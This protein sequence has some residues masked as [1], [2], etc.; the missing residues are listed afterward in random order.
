MLGGGRARDSTMGRG[1]NG[2]ERSLRRGEETVIAQKRER[3]ARIFKSILWFISNW[4][5]RYVSIQ[6]RTLH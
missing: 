5:S 3:A 1:V 4:N 6:L 2:A